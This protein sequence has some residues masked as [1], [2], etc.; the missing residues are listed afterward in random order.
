MDRRAVAAYRCDMDALREANARFKPIVRRDL[1]TLLQARGL[2]DDERLA[3]L[4]VSAVLPF[5]TNAYVVENLIDWS[6][7]PD[8]PIYQLTF[9]QRGMLEPEDLAVMAGLVRRGA[10][11]AE[12]TEAANRIRMKLNPHPAGQMEYNVPLLRGEPIPGMQHKYVETVLFFPSQ[13][14]TCHAYC[15]YCFRWAQFVG[16]SELKFATREVELFHGYLKEHPEVSDVL[17]TGGDPMIMSTAHL[18]RY[19]EPLL[20]PGLEHIRHIRIGTKAVAYWPQR[21][22]TDPDADDFL[23][24][25]GEIREAGRLPAIMAHYSHARELEPEIARQAVR[26]LRD[27]GAVIRTQAPLVRR[28]NDSPEAWADMWKLQAR[29]GCVPYYMFVERDTG[30]KNYFEV[31]LARAHEIFRRAYYSVTGL[32]R[33]VRGPSM[34]A[35]PGKVMVDGVAEVEGR[36]VFVLSFLRG[37]NP[38]WVRRPFFAKFDPRACWLS[39]LEPAFGE[40]FFYEGELERLLSGDGG[41]RALTPASSIFH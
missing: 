25:V 28:V 30:P 40:R 12:L 16:I 8:D 1:E 35:T 15:T 21:F 32:A 10:E 6:R 24:L 4:A 2:D 17:F 11:A 33:T 13:G 38:D 31:P 22:V 27:A 9:P 5:R 29:L 14:Q 39:D 34:S 36:K 18:R 3:M 23:R 37:R 20:G 19:I 41:A 7:I 26:R